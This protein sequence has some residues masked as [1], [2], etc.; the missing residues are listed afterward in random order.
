MLPWSRNDIPVSDEYNLMYAS[1]AAVYGVADGLKGSSVAQTRQRFD[2]F[3]D[4]DDAEDCD[5]V[6]RT[7][8]VIWCGHL[9]W[10]VGGDCV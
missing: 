2:G 4:S 5:I 6:A 7:D 10:S 1:L 3:G 8:W 9:V